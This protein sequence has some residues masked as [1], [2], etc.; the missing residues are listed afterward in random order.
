MLT[1]EITELLYNEQNI[2]IPE[3]KKTSM[4]MKIKI[5]QI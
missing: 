4:E 3:K 2:V 5:V 1:V